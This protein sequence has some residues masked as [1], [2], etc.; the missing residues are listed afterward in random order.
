MTE[1]EA[2][3]QAC[4]RIVKIVRSLEN[5]C[6]LWQEEFIDDRRHCKFEQDVILEIAKF[7][8][9]LGEMYCEQKEQNDKEA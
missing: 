5:G 7:T 3:A 6:V 9:K 8:Q 1:Q 4:E 2:I